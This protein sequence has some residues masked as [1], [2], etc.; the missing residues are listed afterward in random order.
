ML[1]VN[2]EIIG[3]NDHKFISSIHNKA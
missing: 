3:L 2:Q 1:S